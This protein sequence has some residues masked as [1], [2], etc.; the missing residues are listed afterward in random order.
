[1]YMISPSPQLTT[2]ISPPEPDASPLDSLTTDISV[3]SMASPKTHVPLA[4]NRIYCI[5]QFFREIGGDNKY[6]TV[7]IGRKVGVFNKWYGAPNFSLDDNLANF[8]QG[9]R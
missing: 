2:Q 8:M 6:Y 1:M 9:D 5:P 3:M 7:C 4:G